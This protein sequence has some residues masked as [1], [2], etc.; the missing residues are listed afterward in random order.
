MSPFH[1]RS[2]HDNL[3]LVLPIENSTGEDG[4][5]FIK[6]PEPVPIDH[7]VSTTTLAIGQCAGKWPPRAAGIY[8]GLGVAATEVINMQDYFVT[9][10][11][12]LDRGPQIAVASVVET[13]TS[14]ATART[15]GHE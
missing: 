8:A 10:E 11:I 4:D 15:S 3:L 13:C 9:I 2:G 5:G 7:I 14:A 6:E 1:H 12:V